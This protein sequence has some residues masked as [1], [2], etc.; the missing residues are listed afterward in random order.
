MAKQGF[1]VTKNYLLETAWLA[2]FTHGKGGRTIGLNSEVSRIVTPLS[3]SNPA[4]Y[5]WMRLQV[6]VTD[7]SQETLNRILLL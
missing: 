3:L 7:F 4:C 2:T 6:S 1:E 5:R